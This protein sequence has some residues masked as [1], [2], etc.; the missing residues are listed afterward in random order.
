MR[1]G[2]CFAMK[3]EIAC[4][5]IWLRVRKLLNIFKTFVL[6]LESPIINYCKDLQ[7]LFTVVN[8]F[9]NQAASELGL[10]EL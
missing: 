3:I 10:F 4:F 1:N 6:L 8:L 5:Q 2:R 9:L 7:F